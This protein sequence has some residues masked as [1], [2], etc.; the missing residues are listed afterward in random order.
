MSTW[1]VLCLI[2]YGLV[3]SVLGLYGVHRYVMLHLYR[4]HRDDVM[5]ASE[6]F[7]ELPDVTVQLP[8]YNEV[9]VVARLLEAVAHLDY[10]RDRLQVQ[11]LDDSQDE[12][13][14]LARRQVA[15]LRAE[16][17]DIEW[18]H[19][20]D[21]VG[22]KAGALAAGLE[23]AHGDFILVL[24]ADFVARPTS[25]NARSITS[26]IRESAWCNCAGAISTARATC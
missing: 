24:D 14:D 13:Q 15:R 8:L 26:P 17:L 16:G 19:R 5:Q 21:R 22:Y 11:V 9:H 7:D 2:A 10:P 3:V 12:T 1:E 25:C 23:K 18:L 4:K 6:R 20:E